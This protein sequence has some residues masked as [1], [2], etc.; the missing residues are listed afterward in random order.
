MNQTD[1]PGPGPGLN[2]PA[3]ARRVVFNGAAVG[4]AGAP[5]VHEEDALAGAPERGA[6][7][8]VGSGAAL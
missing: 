4:G 5:V 1:P 8:F 7:E 2:Y 6:A 3:D